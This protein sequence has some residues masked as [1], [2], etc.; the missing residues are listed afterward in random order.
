MRVLIAEDDAVTADL[1]ESALQEFGYQ[2]TVV[3]DG[4]QAFHAIRS[5]KYRLVISDWEM[6]ELSGVELCRRIR[7]RRSSAYIYVILLTSH[8][9]V[10]CVVE[11][12]S[13]GADDFL[14]KPFDPHE[15]RVRLSVGQRILG[16]ESRDLTIFALAKLAESRDPET[17][18]HLERMREYSR[19]LAEEL[20]RSPRHQDL[21]DGGYIEL[22]YLTTPLHDIGKV[23]IPDQ[24]LLKPGRLSP[25]EFAIMKQHTLIGAQTLEAVASLNPEAQ[26]MQMARDIAL[27]HHEHYNGGG[28]PHGL[29]GEQ[30]PLC[31]RITAL[32]DVYDAL[33]S[34]RIYKPAFSHETAVE[35]I[36]EGRGTQFDPELVDAFI[37]LQDDFQLI[38]TRFENTP[39][40]FDGARLQPGRDDSGPSSDIGAATLP[41]WP[42]SEN[43]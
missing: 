36:K 27:T 29:R 24:V 12:L 31:G 37:D 13:A 21:V 17:G 8:T 40:V 22:L 15:L 3:P 19:I 4:R 7:Q 20:A 39:S 10:D 23:G 38:R 25:D 35:H 41:N 16:L 5:G 14:S 28:Y 11:G 18:A 32:A 9:G 2:V 1:L 30:I 42:Q 26:Y 34:K 6:P 43:S 33:T